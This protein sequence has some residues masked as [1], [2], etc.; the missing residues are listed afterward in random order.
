IWMMRSAR[1]RSFSLV[2]C[3]STIKLLYTLPLR[4][5]AVVESMLRTSFCAVPAFM[6]VEPIS[7]SGPTTGAMTTS[8]WSSSSESV[9]QTQRTQCVGPTDAGDDAD[10]HVAGFDTG[11][12]HDLR[13]VLAAVLRLFA[14]AAE[15]TVASGYDAT[16]L[17]RRHPKRRR[18]V[19]GLQIPRPSA[20]P[21]A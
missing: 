9:L 16:H 15:G 6:R 14:G 10:A 13:D 8:A 18:A 2:A 20:R 3:K 21:R 12:G 17:L 19:R 4:I 5:I 7:T 1:T 11:L